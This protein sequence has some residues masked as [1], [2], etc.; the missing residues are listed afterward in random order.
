MRT[1]CRGNVHLRAHVAY[2]ANH[3]HKPVHAFGFGVKAVFG[4][5]LGPC[6]EHD[7]LIRTGKPCIDI[8]GYE[9]HEG[10]QQLH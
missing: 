9:W 6:G 2:G 4:I 8:L 3:V 1:L 5:G 7:G 10:M